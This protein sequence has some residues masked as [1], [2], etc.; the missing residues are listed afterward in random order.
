MTKFY[1]HTL[2]RGV[3]SYN[4]C[5]KIRTKYIVLKNTL[6]NNYHTFLRFFYKQRKSRL[7]SIYFQIMFVFIKSNIIKNAKFQFEKEKLKT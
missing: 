2:E 4:T 6:Y 5:T 7:L 3:F 1:L